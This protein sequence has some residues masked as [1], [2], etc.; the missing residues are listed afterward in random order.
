MKKIT[1]S[2]NLEGKFRDKVSE[3]LK[4][5]DD[6]WFLKTYGNAVQRSGVPDFLV[7]YYGN[8]IAI[9]LKRPDG[10]GELSPQ[11]EIE[12]NKISNADGW[13]IVADNMEKITT[14]IELIKEQNLIH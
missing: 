14:V 3:Y 7:C 8:F 9:E 2:N 6:L 5:V 13:V 12:L 1:T 4:S 10:K 11:Q